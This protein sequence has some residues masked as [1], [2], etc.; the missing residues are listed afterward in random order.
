MSGTNNNSAAQGK[1]AGG[2]AGRFFNLFRFSRGQLIIPYAL[3]LVLFVVVPLLIVLYFAFTDKYTGSITLMNFVNFFS[4][5]TTL[6]TFIT[7]IGL[8]VV[9]TIVCLLMAYPV[10]YILARSKFRNSYILLMLF[11]LPMWINF[12]LRINA[13]RE[14]LQMI[15][16]LGR[17]NFLNT[18]IGMVYDYMPFMVLPIYT[19]LIKLDP[20]L[21]EAAKD[22]GAGNATVFFRVTLPMSMPGVVS[23]IIMVF[24]PTMTSYVVSERL[25]L[26]H[27]PI[28]GKLIEH[29]FMNNN[30]NMGSAMALVLLGIIMLVMLFTGKFRDKKLDNK[31]AGLW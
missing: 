16:L 1:P 25:G 4:D 19:T 30:K 10:A 8:A 6:T 12:V 9:T 15:G 22:L 31:G 3:F 23:G 29:N 28:I 21:S 26:G 5:S 7:S 13:L 20:S 2:K 18:V 11:V 27:V 14:F 17:T 24:M